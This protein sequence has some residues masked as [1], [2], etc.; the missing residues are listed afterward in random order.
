MFPLEVKCSIDWRQSMVMATWPHLPITCV[1]TLN[2]INILVFTILW[3]ML[4]AYL[5][6]TIKVIFKAATVLLAEVLLGKE[7]CAFL[8]GVM[9]NLPKYDA[10]V[11]LTITDK[12]V[13]HKVAL[14]LEAFEPYDLSEVSSDLLKKF[15]LNEK[16]YANNKG[17]ALAMQLDCVRKNC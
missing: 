10:F 12:L 11:G 8:I 6:H 4:A 7:G 2:M 1:S 15:E 13:L 17:I 5:I 9:L 16:S 3:I 14:S